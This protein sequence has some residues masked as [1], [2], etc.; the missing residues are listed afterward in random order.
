M[1]PTSEILIWYVE[2]LY[3]A[4]TTL[5]DFFNSRPGAAMTVDKFKILPA[6]LS[7]ALEW[8]GV[9]STPEGHIITTL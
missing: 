2:D 9:V 3:D 6:R 7:Q 8:S 1:L 4:R 5:V